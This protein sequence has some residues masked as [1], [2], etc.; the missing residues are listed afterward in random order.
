MFATI[1]DF[2]FADTTGLSPRSESLLAIEVSDDIRFLCPLPPQK[3]PVCVRVRTEAK[4][5]MARMLVNI[6]NFLYP[7][8]T[9]RLMSPLPG[10]FSICSCLLPFRIFHAIPIVWC[11]FLPFA[12]NIFPKSLIPFDFVTDE[13]PSFRLVFNPI[14]QIDNMK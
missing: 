14:V 3:L 4:L 12:V 5:R 6:S 2:P 10:W 9:S 7:R 11:D 1:A 8:A 13:N